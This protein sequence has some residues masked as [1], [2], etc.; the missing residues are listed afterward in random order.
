MKKRID[1]LDGLKGIATLLV[2]AFHIA[3][4]AFYSGYV[5]FGGNF[6]D[7][8]VRAKEVILSN[9]WPAIY[10]NNSLGFY[11]FFAMIPIFPIISYRRSENGDMIMGKSVFKRYFQLL[12]PCFVTGL[13]TVIL[14][15]NNL[16]FFSDLSKVT[17]CGWLVTINP[18]GCDTFPQFLKTTFI[19]MWFDSRDRAV[20]TMW[21]MGMIL[22]GS[23]AVYAS[24][25]L[26][27]KCKNR[28][29]PVIALAIVSIFYPSI[30]Y[31]AVGSFIT[32]Y[33]F[34]GPERKKNKLVT[35]F[36]FAVG[37]VLVKIPMQL[38][39]FP[40]RVEYICSVGAGLVVWSVVDCEPVKK[41]FSCK[42]L[43]FLGKISFEIVLSHMVVL[44]SVGCL[45]YKWLL[46]YISSPY[47]LVLLTFI[48]LLPIVILLSYL[49]NKYVSIPVNKGLKKL[50]DKVFE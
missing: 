38:Y 18:T 9:F 37:L 39:P 25:A 17:N 33:L 42:C 6:A 31:F 12:A 35:F 3:I 40:A 24:Y 2:F 41:I 48:V 19:S 32:E 46:K 14:Y 5:N 27:G 15:W 22:F 28:Y 49:I 8:P 29:V 21:C 34:V 16:I 50:A 7:D 44:G 1:Y 43:T 26:F 47:L 45:L 30:C 23:L 11:L 20:S 4:I 36:I 10:T 13:L